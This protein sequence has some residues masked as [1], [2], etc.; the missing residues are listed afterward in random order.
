MH[1]RYKKTGILLLGLLL[2]C[3]ACISL[4]QP[5]REIR[6]YTLEYAPPRI[7]GLGPLSAVIRV[8]RFGVAPVYNTTRIVYREAA[9]KRSEY[10]R[11]RWRAN[12]GDLVTY[13]LTRD[14]NRSGLFRAVLPADTGIPC[15][16]RMEG[17]VNRFL[18]ED[19]EENWTAAL[20]VGITIMAENEPDVSRRVLFQRVY[21]VRKPC[22]ARHPDALARAMSL[23]MK[24]ASEKI[25]RDIHRVLSRPR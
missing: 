8:E 17:S 12:P 5:P 22:K 18:E 21:E 19:T 4:K 3:G 15:S 24:E 7:N 23:A 6:F 13:F 10:V 20:S 16:H 9:F 25:I 14:M 2:S 11:F 1:H